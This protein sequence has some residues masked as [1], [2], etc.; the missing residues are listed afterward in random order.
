[1]ERENFSI[2]T[3][4]LNTETSFDTISKIVESRIPEDTGVVCVSFLVHPENLEYLV[5]DTNKDK[6][7]VEAPFI[8]RPVRVPQYDV[9]KMNT[10]LRKYTVVSDPSVE[11]K[12]IKVFIFDEEG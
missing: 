4:N 8:E 12:D 2:D 7:N 11:F 1:M 6:F 10:D 9:F 3:N 5:N